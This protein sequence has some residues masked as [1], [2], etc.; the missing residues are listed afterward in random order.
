M[1]SLLASA[2]L[3][4]QAKIGVA[5]DLEARGVSVFTQLGDVCQDVVGALDDGQAGPCF[6][7]IQRLL[8]NVPTECLA[9]HVPAVSNSFLSHPG[10]SCLS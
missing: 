6:A 5:H 7:E 4:W 2:R 9:S 1:S 10:I 3:G 8:P